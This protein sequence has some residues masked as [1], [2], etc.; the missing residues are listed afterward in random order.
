MIWVSDH[1][2]YGGAPRGNLPSVGNL[3]DS[4]SPT[5]SM[6]HENWRTLVLTLTTRLPST[7]GWLV[8]DA[9]WA[10]G[11]ACGTDDQEFGEFFCRSGGMTEGAPDRVMAAYLTWRWIP[12]PGRLVPVACRARQPL[13]PL[14]QPGTYGRPTAAAGHV[15]QC[16]S[17][18]NYGRGCPTPQLLHHHPKSRDHPHQAP[19][20]HRGRNQG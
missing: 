20:G 7:F 8:G 4:W 9:E 2:H 17:G 3:P 13:V 19:A 11:I 14:P 1:E 16:S 6:N 12:L 15:R 5:G 18:P 10:E